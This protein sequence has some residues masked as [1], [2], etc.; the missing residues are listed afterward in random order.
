MSG[1]APSGA[2][3]ANIEISSI[4]VRRGDVVQIGGQA[5]RVTALVQLPAGAKRRFSSQA[6]R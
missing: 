6:R 3:A 5:C 1:W 4:S 2:F